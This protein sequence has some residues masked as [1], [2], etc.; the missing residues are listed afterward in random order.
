MA[1]GKMHEDEVDIDT[2]LVGELLVAQFPHFSELPVSPVP[3]TGTVNAIYRLGTELCIRMPRMKKWS[4]DLVKEIDWLPKLARHLSLEIPEPVAN[5]K[6]GC[7]YAFDWAIYRWIDGETFASELVSD[8]NQAA[9]DLALFIKGLQRVD[10]T[11]SPPSGRRPLIELDKVTRAAINALRGVLDTDGVM[12]AWE[13][14]L[15]APAWDENAVWI[16]CDLLPPNLLVDSRRLRAVIDFGAAGVGDPAQDVTPAWSVFEEGTRGVF[17]DVL[18]VDDATWARARGYAL[19]QALLIIPYYSETNPE[20]AAM[21][22]RTVNEV[23]EDVR[24]D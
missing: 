3:S 11:C 14:A 17:R 9:T 6:P 16:H 23:L 4:D 7:G 8:Q 22:T 12:T 10:P 18:D 24:S 21:A 2:S 20:F 5:G 13:R 1:S 15:R 19:H